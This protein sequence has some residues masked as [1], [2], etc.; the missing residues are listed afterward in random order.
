MR[1]PFAVYSLGI[2]LVWM[3]V[4]CPTPELL[5]AAAMMFASDAEPGGDQ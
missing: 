5:S 1:S 3:C 4:L 2:A